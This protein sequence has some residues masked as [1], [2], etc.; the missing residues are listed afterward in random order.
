MITLRITG[1]R[2]EGSAKFGWIPGGGGPAGIVFNKAGGR[3]A[4]SFGSALTAD[5]ITTVKLS[6]HD[7]RDFPNERLPIAS[8]Y[9]CHP[10]Q[11]RTLMRAHWPNRC[12]VG[13]GIGGQ[14][15]A[16]ILTT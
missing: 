8:I 6:W 15:M 9:I 12:H 14:D 4:M 3:L 1:T 2:V 16:T 11:E 7:D 13:A 10:D 5:M